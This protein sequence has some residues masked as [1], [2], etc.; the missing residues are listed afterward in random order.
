MPDPTGIT[1]RCFVFFL[2]RGDLFYLF[3]REHNQGKWPFLKV[4]CNV[5]SETISMNICIKIHTSILQFE[6]FPHTWFVTNDNLFNQN[7]DS[8][9]VC[10]LLDVDIFQ[11]MVKKSHSLIPLTI[12]PKSLSV[13]EQI[14]V[15]Q[16][17]NFDVKALILLLLATNIDSCFLKWQAYLLHLRERVC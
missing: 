9:E 14:Q 15:F 1:L 12:S 2:L 7:M 13:A 16:N 3:L 17:S 5:E 11:Y 10:N 4:I 6:S 8:P